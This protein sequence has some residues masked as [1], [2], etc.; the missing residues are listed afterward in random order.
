VLDHL[1]EAVIVLDGQRS[2]QHV[3]EAARRLLGY[4]EGQ[5][6]GGR[7]KLTTR[8]VDCEHACPLTFALDNDLEQ[9]EDFATVYHTAD[10]R[11]LPLRITIIPLF[12]DDGSF[13]GAVEILRPTGPRFGFF[14]AGRSP[15][16]ESLRGR[17]EALSRSHGDVCLVGEPPACRDVA[18]A[19]HRFSGI[20]ENL[21]RLW[22]GSWDEIDPWPPGTLYVNDEGADSV[23]EGPRPKGWR[24][25]VG[26]EQVPVS[27]SLEVLE[28][29]KAEALEDDLPHMIVTWVDEQAPGTRVAPDALGR[30]ARLARERGLEELEEVLVAALAAADQCIEEIHLPV[31][32]YATALVDELLKSPKPLAALEERLIREVL[33]R[34]GWRMQEAAD[35]IGISRVTLWRK[36][37]DLGIERP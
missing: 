2:L 27:G 21:F 9:V 34:C 25:V 18:L 8:G 20:P 13:A 11:E 33:D 22:S 28:L 26:C 16:A 24:I 17:V 6:I 29:P 23:L 3:N 15:E 5:E 19:L 4:E 31:D 7:C 1:G 12:D 32:G 36:M 35:R 10:G 30:L 37:K 14:L